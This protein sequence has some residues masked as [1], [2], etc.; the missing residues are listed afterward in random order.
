M[1]ENLF[2]TRY[3]GRVLILALGGRIGD[4]F[5]PNVTKLAKILVFRPERVQST[6]PAIFLKKKTLRQQGL[7]IRQ[8]ILNSCKFFTLIS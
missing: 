7:L 3:S 6:R 4:G 2:Y 5:L 8:V 1:C